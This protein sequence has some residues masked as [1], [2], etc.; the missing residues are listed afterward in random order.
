MSGLA[1]T[2]LGQYLNVSEGA[3]NTT[4]EFS[5]LAA[6]AMVVDGDNCGCDLCTVSPTVSMSPEIQPSFNSQ[7]NFAVSILGTGS[8]WLKGTCR[9]CSRMARGALCSPAIGLIPCP[10]FLK[11]TAV[12]WHRTTGIHSK[13]WQTKLLPLL[14][15][16]IVG[17]STCKIPSQ[18]G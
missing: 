7:R 16:P 18:L 6:T 4:L 2:A 11:A 12:P 10:Y 5:S 15:D 13:H 3:T 17:G 14:W 1:P 8:A 9:S